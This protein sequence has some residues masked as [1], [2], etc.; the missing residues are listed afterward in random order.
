MGIAN[1][2]AADKDALDTLVA[3]CAA[4]IARN[5]RPTVAAVKDLY[6]LSQENLPMEEALAAELAR[7]Y[8][9]IN[10]TQERLSGFGG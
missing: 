7:E 2:A 9:D 3:E 6:A 8:P 4:A 10:D 5:S 1:Q